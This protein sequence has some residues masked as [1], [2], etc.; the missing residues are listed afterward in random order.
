MNKEELRKGTG[1]SAIPGMGEEG[2]RETE[3]KMKVRSREEKIV[4]ADRK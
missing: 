3:R 4:R 2:E 1:Q